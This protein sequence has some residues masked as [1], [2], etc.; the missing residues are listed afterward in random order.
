MKRWV[1]VVAIVV[2]VLGVTLAASSAVSTFQSGDAPNRV[3]TAIGIAFALLIVGGAAVGWV[4][5]WRPLGRAFRATRERHPGSLVLGARLPNLDGGVLASSWPPQWAPALAPQRVVLLI[6][7]SGVRVL[8]TAVPV[9]LFLELTWSQVT[10]IA[11]VEYVESRVAYE[12]LAIEGSPEGSAIVLQVVTPSL[13]VR[14]PRG[15]VLERIAERANEQQQL[16]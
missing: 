13:F 11:P 6:D 10:G 1:T 16:T 14:F 7:A 12:G 5:Y 3:G 8:S 9:S 2:L 15:K 4:A